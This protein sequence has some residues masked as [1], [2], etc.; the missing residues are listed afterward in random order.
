MSLKEMY[1]LRYSEIIKFI[2]VNN[3]KVAD[4]NNSNCI[5]FGQICATIANFSTNKKRGKKYKLSDFF[6]LAEEAENKNAD[7]DGK[8]KLK[9]T[10]N[11]L[12]MLT[13]ALDGKVENW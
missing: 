6:N 5:F 3:K 9:E 2:K 13:L 10:S 4:N 11:Y 8:M 12:L 7:K 1:S